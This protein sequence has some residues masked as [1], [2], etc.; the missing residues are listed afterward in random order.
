MNKENALKIKAWMVLQEVTPAALAGEL[1]VSRQMVSAWLRGK[2]DS[3]RIAEYL[4]GKGCPRAYF[5]GTKY[6]EVRA[7]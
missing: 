2:S 1:G 7:A 5:R 4:V 3:R 6:E